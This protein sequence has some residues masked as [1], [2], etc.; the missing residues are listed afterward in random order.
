MAPGPAQLGFLGPHDLSACRLR[1]GEP[2][3]PFPAGGSPVDSCRSVAGGG[4]LY[5]LARGVGVLIWGV[6]WREAHQQ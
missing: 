4:V 6:G 3:S 2:F 5:E 1:T